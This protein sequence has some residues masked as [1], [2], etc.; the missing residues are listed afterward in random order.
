LQ[1]KN[2]FNLF[3]CSILTGTTFGRDHLLKVDDFKQVIADS[4]DW[5]VNAFV[6]LCIA[7]FI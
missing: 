5:L 1:N 6:I 4:F 3:V 2:R 7:I